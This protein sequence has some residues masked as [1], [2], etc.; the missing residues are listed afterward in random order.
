MTFFMLT[1]NYIL[2]LILLD[3]SSSENQPAVT[4][5]NQNKDQDHFVQTE[6]EHQNEI[7]V[8]IH[9]ISNFQVNIFMIHGFKIVLEMFS[10]MFCSDQRND[11]IAS[12]VGLAN[13][14][15]VE[16]YNKPVRQH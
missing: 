8:N 4:K 12:F 5:E 16:L 13:C 6:Q 15:I 10:K 7:Q 14:W 11:R 2:F 1:F 9:R 3:A